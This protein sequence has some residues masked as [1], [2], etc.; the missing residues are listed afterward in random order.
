MYRKLEVEVVRTCALVP[1]KG[2]ELEPFAGVSTSGSPQANPER[3]EGPQTQLLV[4]KKG[5]EPPHPCGYMDL[6]HARLPIPPLR[7]GWKRVLT[8]NSPFRKHDYSTGASAWLAIASAFRCS[9]SPSKDFQ[10]ASEERRAAPSTCRL[11]RLAGA[12]RAIF[13]QL[14]V[15]G[16]KTDAEDLRSSRLIIIGRFQRLQDE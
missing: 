14:I 13:F 12:V 3:S 8:V 16:L 5:L 1:K 9:L 7:H 4:P 10:T 6:N 2:L 11:R 15:Q